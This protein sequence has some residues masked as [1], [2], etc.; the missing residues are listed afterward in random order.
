M[1]TV[2]EEG[3]PGADGTP[4]P[5]GTAVDADRLRELTE[6]LE[7]VIADRGLLGSLSTAE[8]ARLVRAAGATPPDHRLR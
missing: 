7:A 8:R 6:V 2:D 5:A 1:A 4:E 3:A